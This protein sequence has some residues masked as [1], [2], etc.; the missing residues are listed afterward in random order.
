M[1]H[2]SVMTYKA[3]KARR[4]IAITAIWGKTWRQHFININPED[5]SWQRRKEIF[6]SPIYFY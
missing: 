3:V 6:F 1:L 5:T 2:L 4:S